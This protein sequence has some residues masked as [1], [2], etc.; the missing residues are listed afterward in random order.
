MTD[1]DFF[2]DNN[3]PPIE[4]FVEYYSIP[5]DPGE[6]LPN[7]IIRFGINLMVFIDDKLT[8]DQKAINYVAEFLDAF[9]QNSTN[10]AELT[11]QGKKAIDSIYSADNQFIKKVLH[12][13]SCNN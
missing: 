7:S 12:E 10:Y 1:S 9:C 5:H 11:P 4:K 3:P 6:H 13:V 8:E 2:I